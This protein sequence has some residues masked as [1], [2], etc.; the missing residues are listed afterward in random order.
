MAGVTRTGRPSDGRPSSGH[1][2]APTNDS[3]LSVPRFSLLNVAHAVGLAM[4]CVAVPPSSSTKAIASNQQVEVITDRRLEVDDARRVG[5]QTGRAGIRQPRLPR[6]AAFAFAADAARDSEST[7]IRAAS[8]LRQRLE[9][10]LAERRDLARQNTTTSVELLL[11]RVRDL[12]ALGDV[13]VRRRHRRRR[14]RRP[15]WPV[16]RLRSAPTTVAVLQDQRVRHKRRWARTRSGRA[17][18]RLRRWWGS[19]WIAVVQPLQRGRVLT[20]FTAGLPGS[21]TGG[22]R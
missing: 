5:Q 9:A 7:T 21:W 18:A 8:G 6:Y 14:T 10:V 1:L 4:M 13:G 20:N 19:S 11:V 12:G 22:P 16:R 17:P 15:G 2:P 3:L